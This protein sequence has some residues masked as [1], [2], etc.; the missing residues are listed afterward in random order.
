[1]TRVFPTAR[2]ARQFGSK[3]MRAIHAEIRHIETKLMDAM[4]GGVLEAKITDSP[5]TGGGIG[6]DTVLYWRVSREEVDDT[7]VQFHL[8]SVRSHFADQGYGIVTRTNP[9]TG[10]TIQWEIQW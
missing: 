3:G 5:F 6:I 8:D 7:L 2:E 10:R 9:A 4:D 1:M